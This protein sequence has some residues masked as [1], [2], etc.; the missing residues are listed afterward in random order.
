[1]RNLGLALLVGG[2]SGFLYCSARLAGLEPPPAG[3]SAGDSLRHEAGRWELA[4]YGT[5]LVVLVGVV[6]PILPRGR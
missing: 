4:R 1:M 6:L 5:A 2:L 3:V